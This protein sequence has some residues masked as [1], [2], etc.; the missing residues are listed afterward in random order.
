MSEKLT[1][2]AEGITELVVDGIAADARVRSWDD[3]DEIRVT[4]AQDTPGTPELVVDGDK[5]HLSEGFA[6][7][8][9]VPAG[10]A[11]TA[12]DASGDLKIVHFAGDLRIRNV[13][14]DLRMEDVTGR[15]DIQHVFA[16]VRADDVA[17]MNAM[18]CD[19]DL[20]FSGG[21]LQL[22]SV[23]GDV[24]VAGAGSVQTLRVHGDLWVERLSGALK[25]ESAQGDVRLSDI[26]GAASLG[27]VAGDFRAT[28]VRGGLNAGQVHGDTQL[29]GPFPG[30]EGYAVSTGGDASIL[31]AAEDDVR[32]TVRA[33]GRV[34]SNLPLTPSADGTTTYTATLGEGKV[35]VVLTSHGD[36]RIEAAAGGREDVRGPW[37]RRRGPSGD[38]FAELSGLGER[39]RQQVTA[40]LAAAGINPET[41]AINVGP[42][43]MR[44]RPRPP[45]PPTPPRPPRAATPPG[46]QHASGPMSS[47]QIAVLKMLEEGRIS[48]DEADALLRALGA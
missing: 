9:D 33:Q 38:P 17:E 20:R 7:R 48:P 43:R 39:I 6:V 1:C 27:T 8:I 19:G 15:V 14:G 24:R 30:E 18:D 32:L 12:G 36:L 41:G 28:S 3:L 4:V 35:R 40:S 22:E 47:E 21:D 31:L 11:V 25:V 34:R 44:G 26:A 29:E 46:G 5:V 23:S 16:D 2:P 13:Y 37:E 42:G 45:E 10:V